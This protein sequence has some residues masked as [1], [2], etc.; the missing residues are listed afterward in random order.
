MLYEK[1]KVLAKSIAKTFMQIFRKN[2]V[3]VASLLLIAICFIATAIFF[4]IDIFGLEPLSNNPATLELI[5]WVCLVLMCL[6][7][8]GIVYTKKTF[9]LSVSK[10]RY[11]LSVTLFV[12]A[13]MSA[14]I[15]VLV[16]FSEWGVLLPI[17]QWET[18]N[19]TNS[20]FVTGIGNEYLACGIN[21]TLSSYE[22]PSPAILLENGKP[23][24]SAD[25]QHLD[26]RQLGQGRY[27][28]WNGCVHFSSSDNSDPISNG[29]I[30]SI[31]APPFILSPKTVALLFM[32]GVIYL[33]IFSILLKQYKSREKNIS[34]HPINVVH[35]LR[36]TP[37]FE[38]LMGRWIHLFHPNNK[39]LDFL[40]RISTLA[41]PFLVYALVLVINVPK[42]IGLEAFIGSSM[43]ILIL[44]VILLIPFFKRTDWF[45][46]M[47]SLSITLMFFALPLSGRW[48][49][50][51]SDGEVIG[52]ILPFSDASAYL[53]DANRLLQGNIMSS[54]SERRPL[55][56]GT[57]SALLWITHG[58][59]P[60]SVAILGAVAAFSCFLLACQI[61]RTHGIFPATIVLVI[62]FLFYRRF[63]GSTLTENLG[64]TFGALAFA[65]LW[66]GA[67][68]QNKKTAWA[69]ILLLT[70]ALSA[71]AGAFIALP[72]II[73]WGAWIFRG[74]NRIS[75]AFF[76][77]GCAAML[78]GFLM[79]TALRNLTANAGGLAFGNFSNSLYGLIVGNKGWNQVNI[80][81]PEVLT[82]AGS[83]EYTRIY[84]LA[85]EAFRVDP[86]RTLWG[87]VGTWQDYFSPTWGVFSFIGVFP[88][89]ILNVNSF[90]WV[91]LIIS[92]IGLISC[93]R[94]RNNPNSSFL[95]FATIGILLS[96]PFVPPIDSDKMRAYAATIPLNAI[97]VALGLATIFQLLRIKVVSQTS[98]V[99]KFT[100][101]PAKVGLVLVLFCVLSPV[102]V[103]LLNHPTQFDRSLCPPE[104]STLYIR[105]DRITW[106]NILPDT[107]A[108]FSRLSN[109]RYSDFING[110]NLGVYPQL[111]NE[112][113]SL[114]PGD[115]ILQTIDL[116]DQNY[117]V[118]WL[119]FHD[120]LLPTSPGVFRI[121]GRLTEN[122]WLQEYHFYDVKTIKPISG[123]IQ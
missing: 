77:G 63:T 25:S 94:Q 69:G 108:V 117:T 15:F 29:R 75:I 105:S 72:L 6:S 33:I 112:L 96:V 92:G 1:L 76:L 21:N 37:F 28:F 68:Q 45:G 95:I 115:S 24:G 57:L 55:F 93:V 38:S 56:S 59:L 81:H 39:W 3:L 16:L 32:L 35:N 19:L 12:S 121:C 42:F 110:L 111:A 89:G 9:V 17:S 82:L 70:M 99:D 64:L 54:F 97:W 11:F 91:L 84:Q 30:Y 5:F 48:I 87:F 52:G 22:L 4:I 66:Q 107:S 18:W 120:Q 47:M 51:Y 90:R 79:D 40:L 44:Y 98:F 80:D 85:L 20:K 53:G 74:R 31:K 88:L 102:L 100:A 43:T 7:I 58:N 23:L 14:I 60:V 71:R 61:K 46:E 78:A 106:V 103:K 122:K 27:S 34:S 118:I 2:G 109:I 41:L 26:I 10:K 13:L 101:S 83:L 67:Y 49:S 114:K 36:H 73:L 86:M 123:N 62:L 8:G 50:G 116:G 119:I 113:N 65:T 104:Y